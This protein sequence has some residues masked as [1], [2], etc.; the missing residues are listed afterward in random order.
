MSTDI[1]I[2]QDKVGFLLRHLLYDMQDRHWAEL[3][4]RVLKIWHDCL[5]SWWL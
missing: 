5:E 2:N 1:C 3:K 4:H